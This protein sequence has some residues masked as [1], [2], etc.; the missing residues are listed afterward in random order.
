MRITAILVAV[1]VVLY[2]VQGLPTEANQNEEI[3]LSRQPRFFF[4]GAFC[5]ASCSWQ[6]FWQGYWTG[7][8]D[9]NANPKCQCAGPRNPNAGTTTPG[10]I[11]IA[12]IKP[13]IVP[14][15]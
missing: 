5:Q 15:Q 3:E 8:C 1:C 9:N 14:F 12:G 10:D 2:N 13:T 7:Y 4:P 11:V 6:C